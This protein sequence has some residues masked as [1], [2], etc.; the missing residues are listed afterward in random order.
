MSEWLVHL[1]VEGQLA[2]W[3]I[4]SL[5]LYVLSAQLTWYYRYPERSSPFFPWLQEALRLAYYLGIPLA[6]A[7]LGL[8]RADLMGVQGD[9][10][11]AA[12][13]IQGF[14]WTD[15]VHGAGLATVTVLL[16]G[17]VWLL[18]QTS[19]RR[20]GARIGQRTTP[21]LWQHLLHACYD[22]VHWAFYRCGPILWLGD[23]YWGTFAGL[24]LALLEMA[25]DPGFWWALK[26]PDTAEPPL[27]RL[28]L[29]WATTILFL[30]THNLWLTTAAHM[31]LVALWRPGQWACDQ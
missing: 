23:L 11:Q 3:V 9:A 20:L 5:L 19:A 4:A 29:A 30:A 7:V 17:G 28:G 13:S 1:G 26:S 27:A 10:W 6:A 31:V 14:R 12:S 22:Q 21:P 8:L 24:G 2:I 15:W 25:L 16:T 18:G